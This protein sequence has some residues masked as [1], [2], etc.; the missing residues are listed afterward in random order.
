MVQYF[1]LSLS[2]WRAAFSF[3]FNC[4]VM[5][6]RRDARISFENSGVIRSLGELTPNITLPPNR[7]YTVSH[8][9]D[10]GN[11]EQSN[12]LEMPRCCPFSHSSSANILHFSESTILL[13]RIISLL[14]FRM[15][16]NL[17]RST[18]PPVACKARIPRSVGFVIRLSGTVNVERYSLCHICAM[19][20]N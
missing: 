16:T 13:T 10:G 17:Q 8:C 6:R 2:L 4:P 20:I 12:L 5:A 3:S 11:R 19:F 14:K 18:Q 7:Y 1:S 9:K 15:H